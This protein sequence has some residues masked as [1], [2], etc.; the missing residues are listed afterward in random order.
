MSKKLI[1]GVDD[2]G[3]GSL[4][5]PLV[6][7]GALFREDQISI[8]R[9][10]GVK[11]SKLLSPKRREKLCE[12]IKKIAL[13]Y[14]IVEISVE[15]IDKV[16]RRK[17]RLQGLNLLEA[18][19]MAKIIEKLKPHI[20]YIDAVDV[21]AERFG[22]QIRNLVSFPL[23]IISEHKA[24]AK[25]P[26][27]SAASIIAKTCRDRVVAELRK[28]YGNFGSG[29]VTDPKMRPFLV[30]WLTKYRSYPDIVRKSWKFAKRIEKE[31]K[32]ARL[33]V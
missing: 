1:A 21:I 23:E 16:V 30:E 3:R 14:S 9:S 18:K 11:N 24:D 5:G 31:V 32:Q 25:Y 13:D 19:A 20:A 28:K 27:V 4:I 10:L 12:E 8:L 22:S 2:A 33:S 29:Y 15:E 7:A 17:K 26:V 6:I